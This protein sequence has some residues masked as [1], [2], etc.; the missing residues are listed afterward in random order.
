MYGKMA[1]Y[2]G[3]LMILTILGNVLYTI[4]KYHG[5]L[6]IKFLKKYKNTL[7]IPIKV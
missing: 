2:A 7:D 4:N 3:Y 6:L 5:K 1:F